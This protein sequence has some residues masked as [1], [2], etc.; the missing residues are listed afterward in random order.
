MD[1]PVVAQSW[2]DCLEISAPET[3]STSLSEAGLLESAALEAISFS[4]KPQTKVNTISVTFAEPPPRLASPARKSE[5]AAAR[6]V[7]P[8]EGKSYTRIKAPRDVVKIKDRLFYALQPPLELWFNSSNLEFPF[9]PFPYQYEGIAFLYSRYTALLADEMG[10]GKT[11]QT[12]SAIRMLLRTGEVP[13]VLL[14]CPK[15]LVT[16]WKREFETWAPE[17]PLAIIEGNQAKRHWQWRLANVPVKLANYEVLLRDRDVVHEEGQHFGLMVIDESQRIKNTAGATAQVVNGVSRNRSWALT[18]TPIENDVKDL[19][20][21]FEFLAPGYLSPMMK[22]RALRAAT[23]D[24]VLRRTKKTAE[25]ELPPRLERGG[26]LDLCE[27]QVDSYQLAEDTGVMK[28]KDL[29]QE[30]QIRH[31]FELVIR[32]KQ[33]CNFDPVTGK[34]AKLERLEA[35]LEEVVRSGQKALVFSQWVST[36]QKISDGIKHLKPLE[37][38]G[39][40]PSATA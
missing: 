1:A 7:R 23:A 33:I 31:V 25:I 4:V 39:R 9:P 30:I 21:I 14:V 11:M 24:H 37:Y 8:P 16:N 10:L 6:P 34:S 27:E 38:H 35:D 3:T 13:N 15:P 26:E 20:G 18:G 29:G 40:V 2:T 36:L 12:I 5:V 22:P 17:I 32:L 28:L 19:V